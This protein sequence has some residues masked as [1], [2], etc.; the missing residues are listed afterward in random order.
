[1]KRKTLYV[2]IGAIMFTTFGLGK[3]LDWNV[4]IINGVFIAGFI[5]GAYVMFIHKPIY[6]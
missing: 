3:L 1:M 2:M 6:K 5:A 4:W